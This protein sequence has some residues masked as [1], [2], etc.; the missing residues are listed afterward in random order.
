MFFLVKCGA[1][2]SSS[3][4][5]MQ[6]YGFACN[7][8]LHSCGGGGVFKKVCFVVDVIGKISKT[9]TRSKKKYAKFLW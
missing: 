5:P 3:A 2:T 8:W 1:A 9:D 6:Q 4:A 7:R